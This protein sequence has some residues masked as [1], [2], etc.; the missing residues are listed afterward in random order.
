MNEDADDSLWYPIRAASGQKSNNKFNRSPSWICTRNKKNIFFI[1][2]LLKSE[3]FA[4]WNPIVIIALAIDIST[5]RVV[6][7]YLS[8][9]YIDMFSN[10]NIALAIDSLANRVAN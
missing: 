2:L 4:V 10:D 6:V 3:G 9:K 7:I 5:N 1:E 8:Y